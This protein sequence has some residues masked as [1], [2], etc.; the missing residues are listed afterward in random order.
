MNVGH[1]SEGRALI[2]LACGPMAAAGGVLVAYDRRFLRAALIQA[3][4]PLVAVVGLLL[5]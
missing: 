2:L 4:P 5:D 1:A 3:V